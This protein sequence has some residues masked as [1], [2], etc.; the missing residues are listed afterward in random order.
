MKRLKGFVTYI[1]KGAQ[2]FEQ[3]RGTHIS[4]IEYSEEENMSTV[5]LKHNTVFTEIIC[6]TLLCLMIYF[7]YTSVSYVQTVHM[8]KNVY[9]YGDKLYVNILADESNRNQ[10]SYSIAGYNGILN[11]GESLPCID[12]DYSNQ[13]TETITYTVKVLGMDR[14]FSKEFPIGTLQIDSGGNENEGY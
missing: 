10:V 2:Y 9:Y 12:Y 3:P 8:P 11:P 5:Y 6:V 7:V 14:T 13:T 4:K 1:Y